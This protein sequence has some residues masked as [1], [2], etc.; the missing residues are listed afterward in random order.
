[1]SNIINISIDVDQRHKSVN[2]TKQQALNLCLLF[3]MDKGAEVEGI[4]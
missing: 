2:K 1:M 4:L 3:F